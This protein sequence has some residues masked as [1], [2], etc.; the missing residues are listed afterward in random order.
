MY[1]TRMRTHPALQSGS[2]MLDREIREI[3][4]SGQYYYTAEI[5]TELNNISNALEHILLDSN[6]LTTSPDWGRNL[7]HEEASG[8][9][10]IL[11]K[12]AGFLNQYKSVM[13]NR[14][15]E[16]AQ[17]TNIRQNHH[18]AMEHLIALQQELGPYTVSAADRVK[19]FGDQVGVTDRY[20][21]YRNN[22]T[23]GSRQ[24][25]HMSTSWM[26]QSAPQGYL[27]TQRPS[28]GY[29]TPRQITSMVPPRV[30]SA[31]LRT[32]VQ[33]AQDNGP[34]KL[35]TRGYRTIDTLYPFSNNAYQDQSSSYSQKLLELKAQNAYNANSSGLQ[36]SKMTSPHSMQTLSVQEQ[37]GINTT[38][39]GRTEY[40]TKYG[41]PPM[42]IPTS[43]FNINPTP[44]FTLHQRPLGQTTY[45]PSN[46]EYQVRYDWPDS[47]KIVRMPW[48]RK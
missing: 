29:F 43:P 6:F 42:D 7:D 15:I 12:L 48:L 13:A 18:W 19:Q 5:A 4:E 40:M 23:R 1:T 37:A 20:T 33:F 28:T 14:A 30:K 45:D 16:T 8:A 38:F 22:L 10:A 26:D 17:E 39:P 34:P 46:T 31:A 35:T 27:D 11:T 24:P 36:R 41:R 3:I 25:C 2:F 32:R 21:G 44:D 47:E 9:G